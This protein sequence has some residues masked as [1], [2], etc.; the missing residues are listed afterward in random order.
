MRQRGSKLAKNGQSATVAL[1][2]AVLDRKLV[3]GPGPMPR[4][5]RTTDRRHAAQAARGRS[6]QPRERG[7]FAR[8][9]GRK[10]TNNS[11]PEV[12]VDFPEFRAVLDRELDAIEAYLGASLDEVLGSIQPPLARRHHGGVLCCG[13]ENADIFGAAISGC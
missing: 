9:A 8:P 6:A 5:A 12:I 4:P 1:S 10:A 3:R 13:S 7:Q 2:S 11:N